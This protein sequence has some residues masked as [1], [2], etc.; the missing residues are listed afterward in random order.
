MKASRM[1][2]CVTKAKAGKSLTTEKNVGRKPRPWL[3]FSTRFNF[4][5]TRNFFLRP[6]AFGILPKIISLTA[7]TANGSGAS[8]LKARWM[9]LC[10]KSVNGKVRITPRARAWKRFADWTLF[11]PQK[12]YPEP[13]N[14]FMKKILLLLT[15]AVCV[16]AFAQKFPNLDLTPQMGWNSW[17]KF[18]CDINEDIVRQMA[19]A[20]ATNG[21][22]DAGYQ[23]INIDDCWQGERDAQGFIHPNPQKFPSGMKALAD[24]IHS[25]GLKF[26]IY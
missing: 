3:D 2:R 17:N 26:G 22:K 9:Q 25:K 6:S 23:Y 21:M 24:Y 15:C 13:R 1:A 8:R 4:P 19:D 10:P 11:P 16:S 14:L 18:Q 7:F 12:N 20:M 5:A